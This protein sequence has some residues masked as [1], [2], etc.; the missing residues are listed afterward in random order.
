MNRVPTSEWAP[1][2]DA[3][4][5]WVRRT[6]DGLTTATAPHPPPELPADGVPVDLRLR[7]SLLVAAMHDL[8]TEVFRRREQLAREQAYG[9]S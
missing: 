3:L 1:A 9:A 7:A 8:E 4:E 6:A 2:L 5:E